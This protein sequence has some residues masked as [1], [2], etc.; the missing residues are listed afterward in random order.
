M[1]GGLGNIGL[2]DH[3]EVADVDPVLVAELADY[4]LITDQRAVQ[5]AIGLG[6]G[7]RMDNGRILSGGY[8]DPLLSALSG[9]AYGIV[10]ELLG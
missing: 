3:I 9:K 5:K 1:V 8:R 2:I 10:N 4:L 7:Y 6:L